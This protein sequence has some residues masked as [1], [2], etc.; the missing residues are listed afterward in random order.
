MT[1]SLNLPANR[2]AKQLQRKLPLAQRLRE[3]FLPNGKKGRG[4]SPTFSFHPPALLLKKALGIIAS[5]LFVVTFFLWPGISVLLAF[6]I[7]PHHFFPITRQQKTGTKLSA[8]FYPLLKLDPWLW[9][10]LRLKAGWLPQNCCKTPIGK[11]DC[12]G[13]RYLTE[14]IGH[15]KKRQGYLHHPPR[16]NFLQPLPDSR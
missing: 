7:I 2:K 6:L 1:K 10:W 4:K 15:D 11:K 9:D 3:R 12:I 16:R 13:Y 8:H 5:L 14:R